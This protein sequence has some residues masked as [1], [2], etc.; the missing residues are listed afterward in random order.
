MDTLSAGGDSWTERGVDPGQDQPGGV[1]G[2]QGLHRQV[3]Y[4]FQQ[5]SHE[6]LF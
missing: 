1:Q 3:P 6:N 4:G 5:N 2:R